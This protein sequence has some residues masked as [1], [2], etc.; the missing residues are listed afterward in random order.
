MTRTFLSLWSALPLPEQERTSL[1]DICTRGEIN[2]TELVGSIMGPLL[3]QSNNVALLKS[4]LRRPAVM[5]SNIDMALGLTGAEPETQLKAQIVQFQIGG[6]LKGEGK[7]I[8]NLTM[9]VQGTGIMSFE[10]DSH[11]SI[12]SVR[13]GGAPP[14]P[15]PTAES[16]PIEADASIVDDTECTPK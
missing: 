13:T 3:M 9:N 8:Q 1:Q 11:A 7:T 5:D 4:A 6:L 12:K 14:T 16:L 10:D 15:L 2:A